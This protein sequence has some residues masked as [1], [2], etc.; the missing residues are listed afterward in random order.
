MGKQISSSQK[1]G[2]DQEDNESGTRQPAESRTGRFMGIGG[3]KA[4]NTF[5]GEK[6]HAQIHSHT[7][8]YS[9]G[10]NPRGR[11]TATG[12]RRSPRQG[13]PPR[14]RETPRMGQ[15]RKSRRRPRQAGQWQIQRMGTSPRP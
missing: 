3:R 10:R 5:S 8:L 9:I 13:R 12:P 1:E 14:Q 11:S 4:G 15:T 7:D 6:A 2:T